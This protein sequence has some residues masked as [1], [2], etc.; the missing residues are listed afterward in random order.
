MKRIKCI[1]VMAMI[2]ICLVGCGKYES[3]FQFNSDGTGSIAVLY[4]IDPD[5][6]SKLGMDPEE[7]ALDSIFSELRSRGFSVESYNKDGYEGYVVSAQNVDINEAMNNL[8]I[9]DSGMEIVGFGPGKFNM[10]RSGNTCTI[11]WYFFNTDKGE[12]IETFRQSLDASGG[13]ARVTMYLPSAAIDHDAPY[14]SDDGAALQWDI[15]DLGSDQAL[16]VEFNLDGTSSGASGQG[17]G[18]SYGQGGGSGSGSGSGS[19]LGQSQT[20]GGFRINIYALVTIFGMI[21]VG[22][23]I[24][25][26]YF[27]SRKKEKI[28]E[29]Y[30]DYNGGNPLVGM[31]VQNTQAPNMAQMSGMAQK[32]PIFG[33]PKPMSGMNGMNGGGAMNGMGQMGGMNNAGS[34]GMGAG[35][36]GASGVQNNQWNPAGQPQQMN[37][38][39]QMSN[40]NQGQPSNNSWSQQPQQAPDFQA[41]Q[42]SNTQ[43]QQV[44]N[45]APETPVAPTIPDWG[46]NN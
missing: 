44:S 40:M 21:A 14:V 13:T 35:M 10:S 6:M 30:E 25:F 7:Y 36:N 26:L 16:H 17:G 20:S 5:A 43:S 39:N 24:L 2:A 41:Q 8:Y 1:L 38:M 45:F 32:S 37:G 3:M 33:G 27:S 34:M 12:T 15:L 29:M 18:Q 4:A 46:M 23:T 42:M 9:E 28:A 19:G 31:G 11:D 22:G